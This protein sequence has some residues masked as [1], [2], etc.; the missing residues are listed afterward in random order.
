MKDDPLITEVRQVR[1]KI[2]KANAHHAG[3]LVRYYQE[4]QR[5][6]ASRIVSYAQKRLL[7]K[8]AA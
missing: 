8:G 2:S 5:K 1:H 7:P 6:H 4:R 3:T